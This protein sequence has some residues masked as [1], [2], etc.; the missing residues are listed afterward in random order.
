MG[1]GMCF[2]LPQ[3]A[4]QGAPLPFCQ[5]RAAWGWG[6]RWPG[7]EAERQKRL[8]PD[9]RLS[10]KCVST[11]EIIQFCPQPPGTVITGPAALSS[12]PVSLGSPSASVPRGSASASKRSPWFSLT[13]GPPWAHRETMDAAAG[14]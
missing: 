7:R 1:A 13:H 3:G 12:S 4:R 9:T 14:G 10:R 6:L 8:R 11:H 2:A 5:G